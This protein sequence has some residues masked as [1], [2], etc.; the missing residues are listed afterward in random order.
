MALEASRYF[1]TMDLLLVMRSAQTQ[2]PVVSNFLGN[3][4][5]LYSR[6]LLPWTTKIE[7]ICPR[8]RGIRDSRG[9][10]GVEKFKNQGFL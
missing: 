10:F 1:S 3:K 5:A 2:I 6:A 8:Q 4:A 7:R 9:D